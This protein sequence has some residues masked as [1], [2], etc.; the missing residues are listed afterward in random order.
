MEKKA[1]SLFLVEQ[2]VN[3][4]DGFQMEI[5]RSLCQSTLLRRNEKRNTVKPHSVYFIKFS[6]HNYRIGFFTL[7]FFLLQ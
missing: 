7:F 1:K 4:L 3:H 6:A 5:M 2:N